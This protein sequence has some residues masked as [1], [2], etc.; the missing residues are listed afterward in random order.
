[1]IQQIMDV[2][3]QFGLIGLIIVAF[4]ESSFFPIPPDLLLIPL[5][6]A[7]PNLA[8]T[9]A[10][11]TTGSSVLGAIAGWWIGKRFGRRVL[12]KLVSDKIIHKADVYFERYGGQSLAIAG[13]SPIPYK[14]FTILSGISKVKVRS[15]VLWSLLGRGTRFLFEGVVVVVL[16]NSAETFINHYFGWIT[17][18]VVALVVI[19]V[20]VKKWLSKKISNRKVFE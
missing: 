13:F 17:V 16:G 11:I 20:F 10:L 8:I 4:A 1:M 5:S 7:H 12:Q 15:V 9:Y 14:V 3:S 2:F 18:A 6:I 19:I